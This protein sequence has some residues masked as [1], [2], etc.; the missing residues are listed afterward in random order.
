MTVHIP[1]TVKDPDRIRERREQI[2]RAA[3]ALFSEKGFHKATTRELARDSG[4]SNGALY[5]YVKSKEDILYLVCQHIHNEVQRRLEDA[6][7]SEV[8]AVDRLRDAL[9]SFFHVIHDLQDEVLLIYQ[10]SRNLPPAFLHDVLRREETIVRLFENILTAGVE[11][12]AW[13]V[14]PHAIRVLAHDIVVMGQMWAFR[15]WAF[16]DGSFDEFAAS[17]IQMILRS[18]Q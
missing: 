16:D 17:Q 10:E 4:I 8:Y 7:S 2:V 3:V 11:E 5:E 9:D 18:L 1:A 6:L 15:R 14:P 12:G 13:E